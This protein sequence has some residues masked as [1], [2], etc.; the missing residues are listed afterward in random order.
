MLDAGRTEHGLLSKNDRIGYERRRLEE[1]P[2]VFRREL[3]PDAVAHPRRRCRGRW[4]NRDTRCR[5]HRETRAPAPC[6]CFEWR[7]THDPW[8][9]VHPPCAAARTQDTPSRPSDSS[10]RPCAFLSSGAAEHRGEE[11]PRALNLRHVEL[12][13]VD[14][15]ELQ[16]SACADARTAANSPAPMAQSASRRVGGQ[17]AR[18]HQRS[19]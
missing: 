11:V 8:S 4:G 18:I 3:D 6:R 2:A 10:S 19:A 1:A 7:P 9:A 16:R 13:V 14:R 17:R 15:I 12:D 5:A